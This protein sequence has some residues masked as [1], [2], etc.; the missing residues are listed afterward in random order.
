M[1]VSMQNV[2][3]DK[4]M[5]VRKIRIQKGLITKISEGNID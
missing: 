5:N 1:E 2:L 4:S 3:I